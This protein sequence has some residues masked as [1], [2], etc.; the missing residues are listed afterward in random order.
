MDPL[1]KKPWPE[2]DFGNDGDSM[3]SPYQPPGA[4]GSVPPSFPEAIP[5]GKLWATLFGPPLATVAATML[6]L[7]GVNGAWWPTVLMILVAAVMLVSL[8]FFFVLV[9]RRFL[10][11][12]AVLLVF[13]YL[14]GQAVVCFALFF[15]ACLLMMGGSRF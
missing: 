2:A 14:I 5:R 3:E 9:S 11:G 10:S 15:G 1:G 6:F 12:H 7:L 13:G 8:I 4:P